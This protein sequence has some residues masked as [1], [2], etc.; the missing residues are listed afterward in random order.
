VLRLKYM[1]K[2]LAT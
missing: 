1:N 2:Q